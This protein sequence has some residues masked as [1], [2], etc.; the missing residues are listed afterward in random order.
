LSRAF[1]FD[2]KM[3]V[4]EG[5]AIVKSLEA[6]LSGLPDNLLN[7]AELEVDSEQATYKKKLEVLQEQEELIEDEAEQEQKEE[8]V[9]RERREA[10]ERSKREEEARMAQSL[11]PDSELRAMEHEHEEDHDRM[12]TEQLRELGEALSI[13]SAKSSVLEERDELRALME[14]N[15]HSEEDPATAANPLA[16]RIRTMLTKIDAQLDAYDSR[17]GSSLQM[18]SCDPQGR[19]SIHDLERA[20]AVI[21]HKPEEEVGQAVIRKLDVDQDGFVIL[22]HVLDLVKQEG[23]GIVVN[24]DDARSIIGQGR[25]LKDSRPRKEDII[26]E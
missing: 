26:S 18:I 10:E 19:I 4:D 13:L 21:K 24:D 12:T 11:L 20:L 1:V 3:D 8:D 6:V 14:E 16:K 5:S 15:S 2:R 7:E 17:V 22:E 9:R 23:L 25:E